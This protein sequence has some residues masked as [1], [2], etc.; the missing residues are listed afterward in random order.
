MEWSR[1]GVHERKIDQSET[2]PNSKVDSRADQ[3]SKS[4]M[5]DMF[6]KDVDVVLN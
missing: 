5:V 2:L 3:I 1:R 6:V 4:Q